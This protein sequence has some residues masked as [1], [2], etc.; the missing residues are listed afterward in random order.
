LAIDKNSYFCSTTIL[1]FFDT[2]GT[3][4]YNIVSNNDKVNKKAMGGVEPPQLAT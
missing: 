2:H 1:Q 4:P 3:S